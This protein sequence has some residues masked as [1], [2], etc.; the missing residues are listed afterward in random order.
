ML[1]LFIEYWL[2][3]I[4]L[5]LQCVFHFATDIHSFSWYYWIGDKCLEKMAMSA[6][7]V[8]IFGDFKDLSM[9]ILTWT[10]MGKIKPIR[11]QQRTQFYRDEQSTS[12]T[13]LG[14]QRT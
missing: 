12:I 13:E 4:R 2:S 10:F 8:T 9:L 3:S 14:P 5:L 7:K 11:F 1:L 6:G